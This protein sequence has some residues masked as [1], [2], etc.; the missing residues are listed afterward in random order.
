MLENLAYD[1]IVNEHIIHYHLAPLEIMFESLNLKIFNAFKTD[2]NG[3]SIMCFVT[4]KNNFLYDSPENQARLSDLRLS[5]FNAML[6][7]EK[8]YDIFRSRVKLHKEELIKLL[9]DIKSKGQSVHILGASTKLNTILGYCNIGP[10]LIK[11][12]AERSPEK[13]GGRTISGIN[14]ISEDESRS[15][16]P[17]YYLVGPYHFKKEILERERKLGTKTKF[18]FPLPRIEIL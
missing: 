3:G 9:L 2:T 8:T 13:V 17:D 11:F 18:I 1:S 6:D 7:D 4:H 5:E 15:M 16:S 10:D 12:A 14:L